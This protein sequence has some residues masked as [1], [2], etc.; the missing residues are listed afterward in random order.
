MDLFF[1]I[2]DSQVPGYITE[3]ELKNIFTNNLTSLN[4]IKVAKLIV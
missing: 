4:D 1:T 2:A 3:P